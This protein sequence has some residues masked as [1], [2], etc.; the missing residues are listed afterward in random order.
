MPLEILSIYA[1]YHSI[2]WDEGSH[3]RNVAAFVAEISEFIQRN[4]I[5]T[6]N[7][8]L[9][10]RLIMYYRSKGNSN[11]TINRK[12]AA[13][14]KLLRRAE[15]AG[16]IKKLPTYVRL[17]EKNARVRFLT[18]EEERVLLRKL[19]SRD[20][21]FSDLCL[22][23]VDTGARVGEAL[24]LRHGD[25]HH[26]KA[27]FWVTKSGRSRT[28]PLTDRAVVALAN[29]RHRAGGPFSHVR[30]QAFRYHW[31]AVKKQ[32]GLAGD[33]QFV[34][35]MLRH[36]CAS[37]L[38]QAGIDLR[39]VQAFLGHQTIQMTLRYAHLATDDLDQCV[40]A[41]DR[42]NARAARDADKAGNPKANKAVHAG[43]EATAPKIADGR[44]VFAE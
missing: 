6:I 10:D 30:Y 21:A 24:N 29:H 16:L 39:R 36:T 13:L 12:L 22:F 41:L 43:E 34:P 18:R 7:D 40:M 31:N 28:V 19:A 25:V 11:S 26:G 33:K 44:P 35:H 1:R 4:K 3:K 23:L 17:P 5:E 42:I 27:T 15:R 2:L 14:Y 37:R 8:D 9:V 38:V 20:E 32:M